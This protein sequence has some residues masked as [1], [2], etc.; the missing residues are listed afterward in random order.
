MEQVLICTIYMLT[1]HRK[2]FL[3]K[4]TLLPNQELSGAKSKLPGGNGGR[5]FIS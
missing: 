1:K 5:M 2:I 3:S 4:L